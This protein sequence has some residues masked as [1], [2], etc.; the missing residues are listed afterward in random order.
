MSIFTTQAI[1]L[2]K[3]PALSEADCFYV[4]F[5]ENYGKIEARVK[6][7]LYCSSKLA[8]GLEPVSLVEVMVIRGKI[9]ETIGGVQLLKRFFY[10]D[11]FTFGLVSLARELFLHLMRPGVIEKDLYHYLVL[12]FQAMD[13]AASP[14]MKRLLTMR[15]VWQM[16]KIL[17]FGPSFNGYQKFDLSRECEKLLKWCLGP[18]ERGLPGSGRGLQVENNLLQEIEGFTQKYLEQLVERDIHSFHFISY[19]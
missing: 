6:A 4:L 2:A 14:A 3:Q 9:R 11:I 17:G 15:F 12:Y 16:V 8:G 13:Q 19:A 18:K 1:V 5:T 10:P 7:A